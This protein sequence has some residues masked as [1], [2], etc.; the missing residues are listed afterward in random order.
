MRFIITLI[1]SQN[2]TLDTKLPS[3]STQNY[4]RAPSFLFTVEEE[5]ARIR[6]ALLATEQEN[7]VDLEEDSESE[8]Y[9]F[10]PEGRSSRG[11]E[12]DSEDVSL[13]RPSR[14]VLG[15]SFQANRISQR[16]DNHPGNMK[17]RG[18]NYKLSTQGAQS[19]PKKRKPDPKLADEEPSG[20]DGEDET[21]IRL[22][23]KTEEAQK[24]KLRA[25]GTSSSS[26]SG[27]SVPAGS[28]SAMHQLV[29]KKT[30]EEVYKTT[31]F[32]GSEGQLCTVT[33]H[34]MKIL[35]LDCFENLEGSALI[36][37][38]EQWISNHKDTVRIAINAWRNYQQGELLK[39]FKEYESN[40]KVADL[41]TKDEIL[42]IVLR[43]GMA[44]EDPDHERMRHLFDL[45]WD[46]LIPKVAGHNKWGPG[47]R[48]Y[49][50]MMEARVDNDPNKQK[51]VT[52]SDEA[53][54]VVL[55]EN[56]I[57]R[58]LVESEDAQLVAQ[59]KKNEIDPK[60]P[61]RT[62]PYTLPKGGVRRFG[63]W[64]KEGRKRYRQVKGL[65]RESQDQ[66]HIKVVEK[67][68]LNRLQVRHKIDEERLA[69]K[70]KTSKV[71]EHEID[72]EH[73]LD[74]ED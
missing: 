12:Q 63:G 6:Q 54:L 48:H 57:D 70:Q 9:S 56:C 69:K 26:K 4:Q 64:S 72:S 71:T 39:V 45:Y 51:L 66:D 73:E 62:A 60:D 25:K 34:L 23:Q 19:A 33:E 43:N 2:R 10:L 7:Q 35:D 20:S 32:I 14:L 11:K 52:S 47:K 1:F 49:K 58:W 59:G 74:F 44:D 50:L 53:F 31:K 18:G 13:T 46:E 68:A 42:Q 28:A 27:K 41:P 17:T 30:K 16:I 37:A 40:G 38:Q 5:Q 21:S 61:R 29:T 24:W 3:L 15:E 55:W 65:I 22:R 36:R 8:G 67:A